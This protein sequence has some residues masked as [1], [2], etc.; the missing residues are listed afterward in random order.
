MEKNKAGLVAEIDLIK[1][2]TNNKANS[3][4]RI[5]TTLENL[6][7]SMM[8]IQDN[9]STILNGTSTTKAI[10]ESAGKQLKD[11]ID[12]L[13]DVVVDLQSQLLA[14]ELILQSN[15]I[16]L[17]EF[18]EIV[19]A[20]NSLILSVQTKISK[21]QFVNKPYGSTISILLE[22]NNENEKWSTTLAGNFTYDHGAIVSGKNAIHNV[23]TGAVSTAIIITW[24]SSYTYVDGQGNELDPTYLLPAGAGKNYQIGFFTLPGNTILVGIK[25]IP[26]ESTG[27]GATNLGTTL[28]GLNVIVTNDTGT[29]ATIPAVDG[30]NAGVVT[31]TQ[32]NAWDN[33][34]KIDTVSYNS[35][36]AVLTFTDGDGTTHAIDLPIENL[37]QNASYNSGTQ[38]LTLTTNGGGTITVDLSTLVDLPEIVISA[39]SNPVSTPS[40]GQKLYLRAD[41]GN[42]WIASGGSWLGPFPNVGSGTSISKPYTQTAHGFLVGNVLK[43]SGTTF[44]K[45]QADTAS[46]AEVVGIVSAVADANNFTLLM[47]GVL[48]I[49]GLGLTANAIYYLSPS[50]AGALTSSI[51]TVVGNIDKPVLLTFSTTE[52]EFINFRGVEILD[53]SNTTINYVPITTPTGATPTV[54]LDGNNENFPAYKLTIDNTSTGNVTFTVS[55]FS[56]GTT[57]TLLLK[58]SDS[59]QRSLIVPSASSHII[60]NNADSK[61]LPI[62]NGRRAIIAISYD[63]TEYHWSIL[64]Q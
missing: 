59:I 19:D 46:N 44:A 24:D 51:S 14:I 27:G 30:T 20:I 12:G 39:S 6:K 15:D 29:D 47:A 1:N 22:D 35:S 63:G 52:A 4:T 45:A 31:P 55:N 16:D 53:P 7:D 62:P 56:N 54:N 34:G 8:T 17:D 40:T 38:V 5:G 57:Y 50:T 61:T 43:K 18:Q 32:K 10:T 36:T 9:L 3:A 41:N 48:D 58:N 37:F 23:N 42:Y 64:Q 60:Y 11:L 28:S 26:S 2:E 49:T 25:G 21:S 13:D 33:K